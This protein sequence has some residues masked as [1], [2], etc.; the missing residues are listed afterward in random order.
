MYKPIISYHYR[1]F[2]SRQM[3]MTMPIR[4][5]IYYPNWNKANDI[6]WTSIDSFMPLYHLKPNNTFTIRIK[7]NHLSMDI[8]Y[9]HTCHRTKWIELIW[10]IIK[11][12]LVWSNNCF[13]L[14]AP[15][16]GS[17]YELVWI[18]ISLINLMNYRTKNVRT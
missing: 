18:L 1:Q 2:Y 8:G 10:Y 4:M 11:R 7:W 9:G 5:H 6:L 17:R 14:S 3:I 13:F 15:F 16:S 12:Q